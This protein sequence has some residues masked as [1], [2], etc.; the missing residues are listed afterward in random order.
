MAVEMHIVVFWSMT[1]G[2]I[3]LGGCKD[4]GALIISV[5]R[6]IMLSQSIG[7]HPSTACCDNPEDCKYIL[8]FHQ[9]CPV[10]LLL[11]FKYTNIKNINQDFFYNKVGLCSCY[12]A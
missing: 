11:Y 5:E 8:Q 1:A 2:S 4:F 9:K 10:H 7:I 3:F 12:K 6:G